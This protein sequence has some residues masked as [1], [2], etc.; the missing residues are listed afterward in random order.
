MPSLPSFQPYFRF[1]RAIII[2]STYAELCAVELLFHLLQV[3]GLANWYNNIRNVS[4]ELKLLPNILIHVP[5]V[6]Q[7]QVLRTMKHAI[8]HG[9]SN[10]EAILPHGP[11]KFGS[12]TGP[13]S[14]SLTGKLSLLRDPVEK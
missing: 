5:V 8:Q 13:A 1:T 14:P 3:V 11:N 12:T 6:Y 2:S 10:R 9:F 4:S 7:K